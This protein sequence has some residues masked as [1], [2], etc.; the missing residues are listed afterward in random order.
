MCSFGTALIDVAGLEAI[1]PWL[2][3]EGEERP[4]QLPSPSCHS[5]PL[6]YS[7][8]FI[9]SKLSAI[10]AAAHRCP[11]GSHHIAL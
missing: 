3:Q 6:D 9:C 2:V 4:D 11:F 1:L 7:K 8:K 5:L 10:L